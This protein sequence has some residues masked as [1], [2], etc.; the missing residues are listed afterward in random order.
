ML[1]AVKWRQTNKNT[2]N[3]SSLVDL[4]V[5]SYKGTTTTQVSLVDLIVVYT[6]LP[7]GFAC[8]VLQRNPLPLC[9]SVPRG[10]EECRGHCPASLGALGVHCCLA[11]HLRQQKTCA[12]IKLLQ[13]E[14][15]LLMKQLM[16][17]HLQLMHIFISFNTTNIFQNMRTGP[18]SE[19]HSSVEDTGKCLSEA[20]DGFL[21]GKSLKFV[22]ENNIH[23]LHTN[24]PSI[25]TF[26]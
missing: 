26:R 23:I 1:L 20:M 8:S 3:F 15:R 16:H 4:L 7:R 6:N 22:K 17:L 18:G 9:L 12:V 24:P 21:D 13:L 11:P 14:T 25:N 5:L 19:A 10:H 2:A